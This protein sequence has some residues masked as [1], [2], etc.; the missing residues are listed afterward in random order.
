MEHAF[1]NSPASRDYNDLRLKSQY[2][3]NGYGAYREAWL[4]RAWPLAIAYFS[5]DPA[6]EPGVERTG[7][8]QIPRFTLPVG[9]KSA[10]TH[11]NMVLLFP[12]WVLS[13][14][15]APVKPA[16]ETHPSRLRVVVLREAIPVRE[17]MDLLAAGDTLESRASDV[18]IVQV[19][20]Q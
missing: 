18:R 12:K 1:E 8:A 7:P 14:D 3:N 16:L 6:S 11:V 9:P 10:G 19:E 13:D 5:H 2:L 17:L 4:L 15:S 20:S